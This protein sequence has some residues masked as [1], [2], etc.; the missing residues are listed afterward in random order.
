[1]SI[2]VDIQGSMSV[3]KNVA[4]FREFAQNEYGIVASGNVEKLAIKFVSSTKASVNISNW[5]YFCR[6]DG[7]YKA[8]YKADWYIDICDLSVKV[9]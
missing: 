5:N 8:H 2:I 6:E 1:M 7:V 9:N 3:F 4:S